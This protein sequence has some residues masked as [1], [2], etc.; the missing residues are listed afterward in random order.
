MYIKGIKIYCLLILIHLYIMLVCF[1]LDLCIVTV[2]F[3][4][5]SHRLFFQSLLYTM[6]STFYQL[7]FLILCSDI[8]ERAMFFLENSHLKNH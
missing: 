6:Y 7:V 5:L 4:L 3:G 1:A 8:Y 2:V